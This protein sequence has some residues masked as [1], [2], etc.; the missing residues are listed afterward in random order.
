MTALPGLRPDCNASAIVTVAAPTPS[1]AEG[2]VA[3]EEDSAMAAAV[4]AGGTGGKLLDVISAIRKRYGIQRVYCWHSLFGYWW[5]H[6][7][8]RCLPLAMLAVAGD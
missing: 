5:V 6:W 8:G 4:I 3:S 1:A 2:A 7:R